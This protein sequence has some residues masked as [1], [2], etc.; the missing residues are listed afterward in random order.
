MEP[1][2]HRVLGPC[3]SETDLVCA[4]TGELPLDEW[5]VVRQHLEHCPSCRANVRAMLDTLSSYAQLV[6]PEP[7]ERLQASRERLEGLMAAARAAREAVSPPRRWLAVAA[8]LVAVVAGLTLFRTDP[9]AYADEVVAR[10]A[11][12]ERAVTMPTDLWRLSFI[13]GADAQAARGNSG[14]SSGADKALPAKV[15]Q[16]LEEHGF[17]PNHPLSLARMQAWRAS[18]PDR[19]EQVTHRDKWLVVKSATRGTLREVE[20]VIDEASY[21]LVKQT[22][23]IAGMGRVVC[24]RVR[25]EQP[26]GVPSREAPRAESGQ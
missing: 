18:T 11:Q 20:L 23:L 16:V 3:P 9:I 22:W 10:A 24:E 21:Q 2:G 13:P 26:S 1:A 5:P 12:R 4:T 15:I 8:A 19:R 7:P 14:A 6:D 25:L 17:D